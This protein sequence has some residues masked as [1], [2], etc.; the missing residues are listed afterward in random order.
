MT[1]GNGWGDNLMGWGGN[2]V[3]GGGGGGGGGTGPIVTNFQ[4]PRDTPIF[5]AT[6]LTFDV[7]T[8]LTL[9]AM[10]IYVDYG[11]NGAVEVVFNA[12]GFTPNYQPNGDFLGSEKQTI[13]GGFHFILRRRAGWFASPTIR[14]E[15]ADNAG[16]SIVVAP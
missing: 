7:L 8:A 6:P 2:L 5:P 13:T 16:G 4:P 10:V 14:V 12:T 11:D 15:G 1:V 3:S 9:A